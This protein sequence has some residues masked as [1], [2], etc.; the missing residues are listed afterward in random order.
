[1]RLGGDSYAV[2]IAFQCNLHQH[3]GWIDRWTNQLTYKVVCMRLIKSHAK[4]SL[5][6]ILFELINIFYGLGTTCKQ[7]R[8]IYCMVIREKNINGKKVE[9][10]DQKESG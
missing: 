3:D 5:K 1:M 9:R 7:L 8:S 2:Q 6:N 4:F 10:K